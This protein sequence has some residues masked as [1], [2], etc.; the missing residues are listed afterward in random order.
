[1]FGNE[2]A[3]S[4]AATG[5]L[6]LVGCPRS[7][8]TVL[9]AAIGRLPGIFTL[10]ETRWFPLLLGGFDDW[11]HHR[12]DRVRAKWRRRLAVVGQRTH[13]E[14]R[15]AMA[16]AMEGSSGTPGLRRRLRGTSYIGDFVR[17]MDRAA[18]QQ[19]CSTWLEKTPEH[20]AYIDIITRYIPDARFIHVIRNCE[21]VVASAIDGQIRYA[22]HGVF[23]G[24]IP[25]WVERWNRA[26][27]THL[28][29]AGRDGHLVLRYEDFVATPQAALEQVR[30]FA[31]ID[32]AAFA[33]TDAPPAVA[34]LRAE[35]WKTDSVNA[36]VRA[37]RSKF[38][39]MFGPQL[40]A[41]LRQHLRD[42][43][44]VSAELRQRQIPSY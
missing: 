32:A 43:D 13:R 20:Y 6:F 24:G 38:D 35:P 33:S 23:S 21:D 37:A 5:K 1:M 42:Y 31:G 10:P 7:G 28:Q 11:S 29:Y 9:Q 17:L 22:D 15:G 18:L 4:P 3:I 16:Y 36:P 40:R 12:D 26:A 34:D 8:T 30:A 41:W 27:E 19:G 44:S 39:D 14:L 2:P 25:Q